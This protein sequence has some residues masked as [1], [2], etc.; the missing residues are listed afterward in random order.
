M[1]TLE[2]VP[3]SQAKLKIAEKKSQARFFRGKKSQARFFRDLKLSN[4]YNELVGQLSWA[5]SISSRSW[6]RHI[7]SETEK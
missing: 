3:Q 4:E 2:H 7:G 6:A 5:R 1:L